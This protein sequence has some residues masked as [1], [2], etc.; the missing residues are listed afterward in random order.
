MFYIV[1]NSVLREPESQEASAY[2]TNQFVEIFF[3]SECFGFFTPKYT[4]PKKFTPPNKY[5]PPKEN[6]IQKKPLYH[7][8]LH[9]TKKIHS[10]EN[11]LHC[12]EY[13]LNSLITLYLIITFKY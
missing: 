12:H 5:T 11:M 10:T 13:F 3:K 2:A 9:S 7:F 6:T 4:T 1:Y 8:F